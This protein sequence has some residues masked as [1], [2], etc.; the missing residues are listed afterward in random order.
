MFREDEV[1]YALQHNDTDKYVA[2]SGSKHSYVAGVENAQ[3]YSSKEEA[4][5]NRCG[6]ERI[7]NLFRVVMGY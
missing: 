3:R 2:R 7:V 1:M 6:N 4:E 5:R